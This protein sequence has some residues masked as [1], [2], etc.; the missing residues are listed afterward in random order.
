VKRKS[1][2]NDYC[3]FYNL[4]ELIGEVELLGPTTR[5]TAASCLRGV[6]NVHTILEPSC[7]KGWATLKHCFIQTIMPSVEDVSRKDWTIRFD[8]SN[9]K[10]YEGC[11]LFPKTQSQKSKKIKK[12]QNLGE[13]VAKSY[14]PLRAMDFLDFSDLQ[15]LVTDGPSNEPRRNPI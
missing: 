3:V 12:I 9:D 13:N 4:R 11:R 10:F 14:I 6:G 1:F 8:S 7:P 2:L 15:C 5:Q